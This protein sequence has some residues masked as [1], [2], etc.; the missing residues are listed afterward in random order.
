M[1]A[2]TPKTTPP[3]GL[4]KVVLIGILALIVA[5]V[6]MIPIQFAGDLIFPGPDIDL[7]RLDFHDAPLGQHAVRIASWWI[8]GLVAG[9]ILRALVPGRAAA[10]ARVVGVLLG[11]A[12]VAVLVLV[13][14]SPM[15]LIVA[16]GAAPVLAT[17]WAASTRR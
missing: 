10:A 12:I 1:P 2:V 9:R 8:S 3:A 15:W 17:P 5:H 7:E 14:P 11:A 6:V 4:L 13:V 16:G